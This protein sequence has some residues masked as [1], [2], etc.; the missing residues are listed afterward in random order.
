MTASEHHLPSCPIFDSLTPSQRRELLDL[1]VPHSFELDEIVL[2]EG[3]RTSGI[4]VITEGRC[5]VVKKTAEGRESTLAELGPGAI[6][7][8]MSFFQAAPHS[9]TV[10][11]L[12]RVK[13]LE[14]TSESY[15][16]LERSGLRAAHKIAHAVAVVL[17]ERLRKMD[18]WTS[19]L[20]AQS[21]PTKNEEWA[22]FRAKLYSNWEF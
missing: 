5:E 7:G 13:V 18:D 10:R 9:A 14:L 8:E 3:R 1:M 19:N 20:L 6:F 21:P 12:S 4:W 11:C 22:E 17:A 2:H 16:Q 15:K